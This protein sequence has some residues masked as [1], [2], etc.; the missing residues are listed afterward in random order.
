M[1]IPKPKTYAKTW[2]SELW[3][4]NLPSYCGKILTVEKDKYCSLH[5]HKMKDETFYVLTGSVKFE[6]CRGVWEYNEKCDINFF[7]DEYCHTLGE[8]TLV[9]D[10]EIESITLQTGDVFHVPPFLLH[11]F[12]GL[13]DNNQIIEISTQHFE[14]D[15]YRVEPAIT[16]EQA[17]EVDRVA[18]WLVSPSPYYSDFDNF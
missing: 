9:K 5:G 15:S 14:T 7:G 8:G 6:Y 13:D 11:R 10:S 4:V 2:G 18:K 3:L 12:T 1:N 17:K 16:A